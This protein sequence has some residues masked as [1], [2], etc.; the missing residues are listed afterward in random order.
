MG[1]VI[2]K[3][4]QSFLTIFIIPSIKNPRNALMHREGFS[5]NL[6]FSFSLHFVE[7]DI[8][9][10]FGIF[11]IAVQLYKC[12]PFT[13]IRTDYTLIFTAWA[14]GRLIFFAQREIRIFCTHKSFYHP[15]NF[16]LPVVY[17]GVIFNP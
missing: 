11:L 8:R 4:S 5:C 12:L 17:K 1:K 10:I 7:L 16:L 3:T 2:N 6:W 13:A 14:F 15:N 9:V